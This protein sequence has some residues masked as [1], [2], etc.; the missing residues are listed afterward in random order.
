V[1]QIARYQAVLGHAEIERI[2]DYHRLPTAVLQPTFDQ[3]A[4]DGM[5]TRGNGTLT[6]TNAGQA[7]ADGLAATVRAWLHEQLADWGQDPDEQQL[8]E[9]LRRIARRIL[10]DESDRP[11]AD[12]RPLATANTN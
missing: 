11:G 3:L 1:L 12:P 10:T 4:A 8:T 7:E 2:A 6:L 9:A 5:I